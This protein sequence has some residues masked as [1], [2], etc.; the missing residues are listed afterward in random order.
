MEIVADVVP[1]GLSERFH[2]IK[3]FA[4]GQVGTSYLATHRGSGQRGLLKLISTA[5]VGSTS[6]RTRLKRE[7]RKQTTIDHPGF[8]P[9]LDGGEHHQQLWLFREFV[10]GESLAARLRRSGPLSVDE[11]VAVASQVASALDELHRQGLLHRDLKPQHVL[12]S[13]NGDDPPLVRL[14]D[15]SLAPRH[16]S[17]GV[18]DLLGTPAYMSPEQAS[19]ML[20]SFRSDLYSLGCILYEML[21][22]SPP[23]SGEV[24]DLLKAHAEQEPPVLDVAV[25]ERLA[26]LIGD[27]LAKEPRKRPFSAQ[28]VRRTLQP[29]VPSGTPQAQRRRGEPG[30][31]R[32]HAFKGA[33]VPPRARSAGARGPSVPP[34]PPV[35][36]PRFASAPPTEHIDTGQLAAMALDE[37][38]QAA[39]EGR[40]ITQELSTRELSSL[41]IH[42]R[43][44]PLV[45]SQPTTEELSTAE[46]REVDGDELGESDGDAV[47]LQ[48]PVAESAAAGSAAGDD[49]VTMAL[50][51]SQ[52]NGAACTGD[53]EEEPQG[54]D[55]NGDSSATGDEAEQPSP[56]AGVAAAEATA[57]PAQPEHAGAAGPQPSVPAQGQVG[58]GR[59]DRTPLPSSMRPSV[60]FDVESLFSDEVQSV[61][62]HDGRSEASPPEGSSPPSVPAQPDAAP[63]RPSRWLP[64]AAGIVLLAGVIGWL[65]SA[66][67]PDGGATTG[68]VQSEPPVAAQ[69]VTGNTPKSQ[70]EPSR[71]VVPTPTTAPNQ[72]PADSPLSAAAGSADPDTTGEPE[73]E[74]ELGARVETDATPVDEAPSDDTPTAP[75]EPAIGAAQDPDQT[76]DEASEE[77]SDQASEE[78]SDQASDQGAAPSVDTA[79]KAKAPAPAKASARPQPRK[80]SGDH[81]QQARAHFRAKRFNQAAAAYRA[82]TKAD[83]RDSGAFAGLGASLLAAGRTSQAVSAYQRAVKLSPSVSGFHAA[84]GRAYVQRGDRARAVS[85]YRQA[86]KLNPKNKA[87]LA[88]LKKLGA[89]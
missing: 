40:P 39:I 15:A 41:A 17:S 32:S 28:Q 30:A 53:R 26:Q 31:H 43:I 14:I 74:T 42:E 83:P 25:P 73:T 82:A 1:P 21:T 68:A 34:P 59:A 88:A 67:A 64:V 51:T 52:A 3:P 27:L 75:E 71:P 58:V 4:R 48:R 50:D 76:L 65:V 81:K 8:V 61:A 36:E 19:N 13:P 33:S 10:E 79:S 12:L 78:A 46:L 2:G 72:G 66:G 45:P 38:E 16:A 20:V 85:A 77:A 69:A 35:P 22:G 62:E 70:R 89:D 11:T 56:R 23:F 37:V 80:S 7:L 44:A 55:E 24:D 47:E 29:F 5:S 54:G 57:L 86:A 9:I 87:A 18:F 6:D 84:L 49:D 60:D 63:A